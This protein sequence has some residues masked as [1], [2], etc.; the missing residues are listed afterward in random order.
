MSPELTM[1]E[2][3][4]DC[5]TSFSH[6]PL[7]GPNPGDVRTRNSDSAVEP[8]AQPAFVEFLGYIPASTALCSIPGEELPLGSLFRSSQGLVSGYVSNL[9]EI[10]TRVRSPPLNAILRFTPVDDNPPAS[11]PERP[12]ML[13]MALSTR[14]GSES[15]ESGHFEHPEVDDA[16]VRKRCSNLNL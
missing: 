8:T 1:L 15:S 12:N 10:P 4:H 3:E 9:R 5:G 14:R 11:S 16:G 6:G 2:G 7:H 13:D